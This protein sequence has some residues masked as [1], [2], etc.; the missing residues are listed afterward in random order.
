MANDWDFSKRAMRQSYRM[1]ALADFEKKM[2]ELSFATLFVQQ[3]RQEKFLI[4]I[5]VF[6]WIQLKV[7]TRTQINFS[8]TFKI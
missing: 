6:G 8:K 1:K 7:T 4:L 2:E 3:K 5:T